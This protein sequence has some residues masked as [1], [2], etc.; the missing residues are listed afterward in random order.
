VEKYGTAR[1]A[2]D[3]NI[4]QGMRIAG[5]IPKATNTHSKHVML[6]AFAMQQRLCKRASMLLD[7][8]IASLIIT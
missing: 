8:Y 4:I 3:E 1:Q 7:T 6:F 2:T 5:W